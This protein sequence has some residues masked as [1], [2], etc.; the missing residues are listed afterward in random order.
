[1]LWGAAYIVYCLYRAR[2]S[3]DQGGRLIGTLLTINCSLVTMLYLMN[4]DPIFFQVTFAIMVTVGVLTSIHHNSEQYSALGVKFFFATLTLTIIA[5]I[6]W[7]V[8][9]VFCGQLR[10]TRI[11][12]FG[13][14]HVLRYLSPITQL[15]G[16]WHLL[17]G[18]AFYIQILACIQQRLL[19]LNIEHSVEKTWRTGVEVK[20][21]DP[22]MDRSKIEAKCEQAQYQD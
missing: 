13:S 6:C 18:Y 9:N 15:H 4:Q 3:W 19:F 1:M 11:K 12:T 2:Y 5:F 7:N 8:D 22:K 16:W 10:H 21:T 14:H 20:I 17:A